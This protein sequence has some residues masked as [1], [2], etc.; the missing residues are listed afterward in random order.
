MT[1]LLLLL[2]NAIKW[3]GLIFS[4]IL[5]LPLVLLFRI[6]Q[7]NL[8]AEKCIKWIE[9]TSKFS[10]ASAFF[11]AVLMVLS[12][13]IV[14][15]GRYVFGW[16]ATWL[17]EIVIYTYAAMFLLA[18]AHTLYSDRH[19]RV[20]I[21]RDRITPLMKHSIELSGFYF[22]IIPICILI[23]WSSVSRS[24]VASWINFEGSRESD[25]L[26]LYFIFRSLIPIFA[27]LLLAQGLANAIKTA[28]SITALLSKNKREL[29][30][31]S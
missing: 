1:E 7:I 10:L 25:G 15:F 18:A 20:D 29:K 11:C 31:G 9:V 8:V 21:F 4:P 14:I 27:T 30:N 12:Q 26:P 16:S 17:N 19:V 2:G 6:R 28:N 3:A 23:L 5:L 24:F 22:F 13:L